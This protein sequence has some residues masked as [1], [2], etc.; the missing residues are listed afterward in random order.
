MAEI[1]LIATDLDGTFL[2]VGIR[3]IRRTSRPYGPAR[4]RGL[5]YALVRGETG[6][7]AEKIVEEV[8]FDDFVR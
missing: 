2:K 1:K 5:E 4:K 6:R 7:N 3:R 8:G